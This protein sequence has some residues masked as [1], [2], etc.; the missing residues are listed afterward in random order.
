MS[1]VLLTPL[2][3]SP[4]VVAGSVS[5]Q[6]ITFAMRGASTV[7][8]TSM[9]VS[10]DAS[11]VMDVQ[12]M[13]TQLLPF[14]FLP[15][16]RMGITGVGVRCGVRHTS[17]L[18][19][20]NE[21]A[22]LLWDFIAEQW[23][24]VVTIALPGGSTTPIEHL[25]MITTR[26]LRFFDTQ[27]RLRVRFVNA[28]ALGRPPSA[29]S[30]VNL[31]FLIYVDAERVIPAYPTER[32]NPLPGYGA[33]TIEPSN[34]ITY[35]LVSSPVFA[36]VLGQDS[37][38]LSTAANSTDR[39]GCDLY[40]FPIGAPYERIVLEMSA[41]HGATSDAGLSEVRFSTDDGATFESIFTRSGAVSSDVFEILRVHKSVS[42]GAF[43]LRAVAENASTG[44]RVFGLYKPMLYV[45]L[46]SDKTV[47]VFLSGNPSALGG[48]AS[49]DYTRTRRWDGSTLQISSYVK[50]I[51]GA[52]NPRYAMHMDFTTWDPLPVPVSQIKELLIFA[53]LWNSAGVSQ[54]LVFRDVPGNE[55]ASGTFHTITGQVMGTSQF[56]S[57]QQLSL[58]VTSNI[59]NFFSSGL[60]FRIETPQ[61][62]LLTQLPTSPW[63]T[64]IDVLYVEAVV[65]AAGETDWPFGVDVKGRI[66]ASRLAR[67][68]D[69]RPAFLDREIPNLAA[70]STVDIHIPKPTGR[71]LLLTDL[72][73]WTSGPPSALLVSILRN[74]QP[75]PPF[76]DVVL[77]PVIEKE[78]VMGKIF[79]NLNV[80]FDPSEEGAVRVRNLGAAPVSVRVYVVG[81]TWWWINEMHGW[82]FHD[83]SRPV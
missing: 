28:K 37:V 55:W 78:G 63:T 52:G 7:T 8:S 24:E 40:S 32:V 75:I 45:L 79:G 15:V 49:G 58:I 59:S 25:E 10:D 83:L 48:I 22:L 56:T 47:R 11:F 27:G 74:G 64:H 3:V 13:E 62:V 34:N 81:F 16:Q 50:G 19:A 57:P 61:A 31:F 43:R 72:Y 18:F 44:S 35:Q 67:Y 20:A 36:H 82:Q 9:L 65:P 26:P 66:I 1:F 2:P 21:Y 5:G 71:S 68:R 12:W 4:T 29:D 6:P 42:A 23:V 77:S 54:P 30:S 38:R 60:R 53:G 73:V 69:P 46:R 39:K 41:R 70:G 80:Y 17:T 14:P 76:H 51:D 33:A